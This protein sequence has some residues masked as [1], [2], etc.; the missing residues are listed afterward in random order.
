MDENLPLTGVRVV[1]RTDG[2]GETTGRL[3]ADLGADVIRVDRTSAVK[4]GAATGGTDFSNRGKRSI[5]VDLKSEKGREVVF[6]LVERADVLL[7]GF[8]PGVTERLGL[9]PDDCLARNPKLVYGRMTGWGQ[10]GPLS[11]SA[12]HDIGYIAITG[13]LHAIGRE[14]GP[15]QVPRRGPGDPRTVRPVPARLE[16]PRTP[17]S[18]PCVFECHAARDFAGPELWPPSAA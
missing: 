17:D 15:P 1:D 13:A 11:S 3:L 7:E 2:L 8:R 10:E 16:R 18:V 9:G 6:R 14:G 12:G 5:A 4:P